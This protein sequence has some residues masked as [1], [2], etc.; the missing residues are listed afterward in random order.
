[1]MFMR[2]YIEVNQLL[3]AQPCLCQRPDTV[4]AFFAQPSANISLDDGF[5]GDCLVTN[6]PPISATSPLNKRVKRHLD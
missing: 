1:M 6:R 2:L 3:F 4:Y 5:E